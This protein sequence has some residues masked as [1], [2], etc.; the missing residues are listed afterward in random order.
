M[1][2]AAP[3]P[4]PMRMRIK[5]IC[6]LCLSICIVGCEQRVEE[7]RLKIAHACLDYLK[8]VGRIQKD[9]ALDYEHLEAASA[10]QDYRHLY[11]TYSMPQDSRTSF[12]EACII[13]STL[14]WGSKVDDAESERILDAE[15]SAWVDRCR[16]SVPCIAECGLRW[17]KYASPE[18]SF[19]AYW[20]SE[21]C[22]RRNAEEFVRG[23]Y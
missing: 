8:G 13:R 12:N 19:T 1:V 18:D 5:E 23:G 9:A 2:A 3:R 7:G 16:R 6:F 20:R 17:A 14:F 10:H 15:A 21:T 4:A 11:I 22:T